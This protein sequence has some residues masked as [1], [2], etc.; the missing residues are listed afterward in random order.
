MP[1]KTEKA[2][3]KSAGAVVFRKEGRKRHYLLLCYA[4]GHWDFIKGHIEEEE[5]DLETVQREAEEETG[6][7]DLEILPEFKQDIHYEFAGKGTI[8]SKDVFFY[9]AETKTK[10]IRLSYEHVNFEW[11]EFDDA[12]RKLT[13]ENAKDVLRKA[14]RFLQAGR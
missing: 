3:E 13:F 2:F 9:L 5:D 10:E 6:L 11:L 7:V 12:V 8:I 4:E 1:N 14:E